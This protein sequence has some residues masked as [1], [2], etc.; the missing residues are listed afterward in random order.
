M[1]GQHRRLALPYNRAV[2]NWVG[3][4]WPPLLSPPGSR[5]KGGRTNTDTACVCV[6][7]VVQR[8][9][10]ERCKQLPCEQHTVSSMC[11]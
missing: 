7:P 10:T 4:C 2:V 6:G 5:P 11:A 8:A 9:L 1:F 3:A